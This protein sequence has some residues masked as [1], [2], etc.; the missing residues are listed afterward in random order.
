M[1]SEKHRLHNTEPDNLISNLRGEV[2]EILLTWL[3][4]RKLR[5]NTRR[6]YTDDI[7]KDLLNSDLNTLEIL[8]DKLENDVVSR[9]SELS[10]KKIG[11]LTFHFAQQKLLTQN[12]FKVDVDEFRKF[13][14][15]N[16]FKKRRDQFIS[17][18][19]LPE[20][21]TDHKDIFIPMVT[22]GKCIAIAVS[23]M[24]K[25]DKIFLGPCAIYLWRETLKKKTK[26]IIPLSVNFML[27]PHMNLSPAIRE[28]VMKKE[29]EAGYKIWEVVQAKVNGVEKDVIVCKKWGAIM[30]NPKLILINDNY[31]LIELHEIT[32]PF[33]GE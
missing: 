9:L 26:P 8:I 17:H 7:Q 24:I 33:S 1:S 3:L 13:V 32:I 14:V 23:L 2:G 6:L 16:R 21:W 10:E 28:I 11:Q 18:K 31:P 30:L 29:I 5:S 4:L 12:D 19:Q 27:L 15:K 25:I 22:I 20:K